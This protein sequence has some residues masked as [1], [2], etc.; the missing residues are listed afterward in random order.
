MKGPNAWSCLPC[1]ASVVMDVPLEKILQSLGHDGYA[2]VDPNAPAALRHRGFHVHEIFDVAL[3]LG[4]AVTVIERD[5]TEQTQEEFLAG[6]PGRELYEGKR[7]AENRFQYY[8]NKYEG[9]LLGEHKG[10]PHAVAWKK[11]FVHDSASGYAYT[12]P[13][14]KDFDCDTLLVFTIQSPRK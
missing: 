14:Y 1:S 6:M 12:L 5:P 3:A 10:V 4:W 11:G 13:D 8:L 9:I 7:A 2:V